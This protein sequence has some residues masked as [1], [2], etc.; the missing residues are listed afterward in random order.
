M[1]GLYW[2]GA[3][4]ATTDLPCPAGG[5]VLSTGSQGGQCLEDA[6]SG[7]CIDVESNSSYARCE[8]GCLATHG[9]GSCSL[10]GEASIG[11]SIVL[12]CPDGTRYLLR[13]GTG[14]GDCRVPAQLP[15][16]SARCSDGKDSSIEATCAS[17]CAKPRGKGLCAVY[18]T[19]AGRG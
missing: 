17:G 19:E 2:A 8:S 12:A 5:L 6:V 18:K 4:G 3:R 13:S 7:V 11:G 1:T 15:S 14:K 9:T 10:P 16:S